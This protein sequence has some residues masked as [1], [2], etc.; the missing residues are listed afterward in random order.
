MPYRV[1]C[2]RQGPQAI[3]GFSEWH[4]DLASAVEAFADHQQRGWN[5][6]ALVPQYVPK[7]YQKQLGF[8]LKEPR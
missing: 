7:P 8:A 6:V 3:C 5:S 2:Y 4:R 1:Q